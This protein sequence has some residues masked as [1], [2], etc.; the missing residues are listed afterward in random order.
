MNAGRVDEGEL[1]DVPPMERDAG[2]DEAGR[3]EELRL[4]KAAERE[5]DAAARRATEAA[6]R[7]ALA[8]RDASEQRAR[9]EAAE[10]ELA[11]IAGKRDPARWRITW[12][13]RA[14]ARWLPAGL[15]GVLRK[16]LTPARWAERLRAA[17][18]RQGPSR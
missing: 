4:R 2:K 1:P 8:R 15:K 5:R 18:R 7:A 14:A 6:R 10:A 9:A 17:A 12:P 13:L 3:R 11:R 16:S